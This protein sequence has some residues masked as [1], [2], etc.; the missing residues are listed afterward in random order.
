MPLMATM[1]RIP[2]FLLVLLLAPPQPAQGWYPRLASESLLAESP[3]IQ[4]VGKSRTYILAPGEVLPEIARRC[5]IGYRSLLDANPDVDP[6][7]PGEWQEILLPYRTIL[8]AGIEPGITINL[9]EFRLYLVWNEGKKKRVRIYPVGI[10]QQGWSTPEGRFKI[11]IKIDAPSWSKPISLREL[12]Q[13]PFTVLPGPENP[14]GSHWFG[15]SSPG[16]GIHGTSEPFGVGRRVSHGCIRLYPTDI[17]DLERLTEVGM[18]VNIIYQPIK[19][20][21]ENGQLFAQVHPDFLGRIEAPRKEVL[22]IEEGLGW[23][24][25]IDWQELEKTLREARGIPMPVSTLP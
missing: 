13:G 15:L 16:L 20:A 5:R 11:T 22:K 21:V 25:E 3:A 8:P 7:H 19:L 6:W 18:P 2:I 12:E 24:G 17:V 4:I 1:I 23:Q 9:A 10:G 14:L